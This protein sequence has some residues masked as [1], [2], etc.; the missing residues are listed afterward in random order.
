M[1]KVGYC[2][3]FGDLDAAKEDLVDFVHLLEAGLNGLKHLLIRTL[4]II[5]GPL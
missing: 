1:L 5:R 3:E 2:G 4:L